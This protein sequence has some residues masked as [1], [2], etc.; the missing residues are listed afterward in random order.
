MRGPVCHEVALG[1][2]PFSLSQPVKGEARRD[3]GVIVRA[4]LDGVRRFDGGSSRKN[5]GLEECL[6]PD[7]AIETRDDSG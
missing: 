5:T 4:Y 3:L 7:V 6:V 1:D 2:G